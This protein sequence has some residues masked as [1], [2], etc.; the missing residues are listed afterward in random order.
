[1]TGTLDRLREEDRRKAVK[2]EQPSWAAPMLATLTHDPFSDEGWVYERKLDGVRVLERET[3]PFEAGEP[4]PGGGVHWV[5]RRLVAEVSF[6]EWTGKGRLRHPS[7]VGL[8][9]DKNPEDVVRERSV[10]ES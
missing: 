10:E 9:A 6:T 4:G 2:R 3:S 8:R 1:M 5:T 7:F